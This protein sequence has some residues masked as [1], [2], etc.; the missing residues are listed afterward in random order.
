[1]AKTS[2][3]ARRARLAAA[4]RANLKRR[5]TGGR[6]ASAGETETAKTASETGENMGAADGAV[7]PLHEPR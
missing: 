3:E 4:L 1:M 2:A 5:K 6:A 7:S